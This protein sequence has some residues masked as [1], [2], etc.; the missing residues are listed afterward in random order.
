[1]KLKTDNL[2]LKE[3]KKHKKFYKIAIEGKHF[4]YENCA[5]S[6]KRVSVGKDT[7]NYENYS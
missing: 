4:Y 3:G 1:M 2:T 7:L 5:M 6:G